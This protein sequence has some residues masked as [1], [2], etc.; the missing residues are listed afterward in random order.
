MKSWRQ[1]LY[2]GAISGGISSALSTAMLGAC[3][4][5]EVG[6]PF[7]PANAI[8]HWVW[9]DDAADHDGPHLRYT[10]L[11]YAI[12]HGA[13]T[14]WATVYEKWFGH[15]ADQKAALPALTGGAAV[16]ALACFVDYELTP[17]RLRPGYEKRLSKKSLFFVYAAVGVGFAV[18]GLLTPNRKA[19]NP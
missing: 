10:A 13:S 15:W 11:G 16:A 19:S 7:A 4:Q 14:L 5:H 12:H 1:A 2:D 17:K 8:S 9:G 18:R 3:G 6:S